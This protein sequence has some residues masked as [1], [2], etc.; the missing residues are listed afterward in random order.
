MPATI[1]SKP[2]SITAAMITGKGGWGPEG[3]GESSG[4]WGTSSPKAGIVIKAQSF[5]ARFFSPTQETTGHS[6]QAPVWENAELIYGTWSLQGFA[7]AAGGTAQD[8]LGIA[9]LSDQTHDVADMPTLVINYASG[10]QQTITVII[11]RIRTQLRR[12]AAF[13]GVSCSGRTTDA[14]PGEIS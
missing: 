2:G 4:G 9:Y 11:E 6:D 10:E 12:N 13:V 7:V 1:L 3:Q 5:R 8:Q 14:V